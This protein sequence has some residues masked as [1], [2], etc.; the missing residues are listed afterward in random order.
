MEEHGVIT[1]ARVDKFEGAEQGADLKVTV[2]YNGKEY[3]ST[4][5]RFCRGCI[6]NYYYI[7]II[8]TDPSTP[9]AELYEDKPVPYCYI[10]NVPFEGWKKIPKDTCK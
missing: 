3:K 2:F 8:P 5:N 7:K 10:G 4:L 9:A 1:I 6:G